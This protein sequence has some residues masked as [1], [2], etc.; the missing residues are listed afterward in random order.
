MAKAVVLGAVLC[1]AIAPGTCEAL[2]LGLFPRARDPRPAVREATRTAASV[3]PRRLLVAWSGVP[4]DRGN[5]TISPAP[6]PER[7]SSTSDQSGR[8]PIATAPASVPVRH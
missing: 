5:G 8:V 1:E 6:L 4:M 3:R 7:G 2:R